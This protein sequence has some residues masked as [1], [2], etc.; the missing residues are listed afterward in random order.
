MIKSG[1]HRNVKRCHSESILSVHLST[2]NVGR[3]KTYKLCS[4]E[5]ENEPNQINS[6]VVI[7]KGT[8]V[9]PPSSLEIHRLKLD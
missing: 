9:E 1:P 8:H 3:E 4:K 7:N 5:E 2:E 6:R